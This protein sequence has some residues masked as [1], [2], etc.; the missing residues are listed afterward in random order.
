[1]LIILDKLHKI[2]HE[3]YFRIPIWSL[4]KLILFSINSVKLMLVGY[5]HT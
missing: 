1:M 5:A 2:C 4:K 3:L